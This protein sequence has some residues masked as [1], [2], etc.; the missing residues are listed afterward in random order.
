MPTSSAAPPSCSAGRS[1]R[2]RATPSWS[3]RPARSG[4]PT[5]SPWA[6]RRN[7]VRSVTSRQLPQVVQGAH[8]GAAGLSCLDWLL[9]E[10]A[11]A[12][13]RQPP[14]DHTPNARRA[15]PLRLG[16]GRGPAR[17]P[18]RLR[19]P[20]GRRHG[21]AEGGGASRRGDAQA[22]RAEIDSIRAALAELSAGIWT[23]RD[24]GDATLARER[25]HRRRA[26]QSQS[27]RSAALCPS[28]FASARSTSSGASRHASASSR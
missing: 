22:S 4:S 6:L 18:P 10:N 15:L 11:A 24:G 27:T 28:G 7:I 23:D 3:T 5:L 12:G 2:G 9:G 1:S 13:P 25:H 21:I 19:P 17:E 8:P 26:L 16:T 20:A 14:A